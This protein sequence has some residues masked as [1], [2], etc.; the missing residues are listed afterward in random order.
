MAEKASPAPLDVT[1]LLLAWSHGDRAALDKLIPLVYRELHRLAHRYMRQERPGLGNPTQHSIG[2]ALRL[3]FGTDTHAQPRIAAAL[4]EVDLALT[5]Q[6]LTRERLAAELAL[7]RR[8][9]HG[10]QAQAHL[11]AQLAG[12][13]RERAVHID[14][15]FKAGESPLPELLRALSAAAQA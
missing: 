15:A 9:L 13:L 3:P 2:I 12:L 14:K 5:Q 10:V 4:S 6:Q 1:Q 8:Q 7:A 11:E